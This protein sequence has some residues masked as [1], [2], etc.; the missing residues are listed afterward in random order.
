MITINTSNQPFAPFSIL[1]ED[2]FNITQHDETELSERKIDGHIS[3]FD[4]RDP[5]TEFKNVDMVNA[6]IESE[7][8]NEFRHVLEET[9]N[10]LVHQRR[11]QL[12]EEILILKKDKPD[13]QLAVPK[14]IEKE[15]QDGATS[16]LIQERKQASEDEI[17]LIE[18][19]FATSLTEC[20]E[21]ITQADQKYQEAKRLG[22]H[23]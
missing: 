22:E 23:H 8:F 9:K 10:K 16:K 13:L 2:I 7:F 14:H 21:R 20:Q 11:F 1:T 19:R 3:Y 17:L 4:N 15:L 12:E 6:K 5:N 18:S